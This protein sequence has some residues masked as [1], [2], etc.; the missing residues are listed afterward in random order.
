M[1]GNKLD[2]IS[3]IAFYTFVS[4]KPLD[5]SADL[6]ACYLPSRSHLFFTAD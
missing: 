4:T 6:L 1:S 3:D 5:V 2:L